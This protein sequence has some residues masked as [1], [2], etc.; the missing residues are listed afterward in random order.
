MSTLT[1]HL[2]SPPVWVAFVCFSL[3]ILIALAMGWF[4]RTAPKEE[5]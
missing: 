1:E 3:A 4:T 2:A 5:R